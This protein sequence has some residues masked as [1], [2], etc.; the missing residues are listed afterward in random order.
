[1]GALSRI[2]AAAVACAA[3]A[4]AAVLVIGDSTPTH[5]VQPSRTLT[6]RTSFAPPAAQFGD[7]VVARVVVLADRS[8]LD[9]QHLRITAGVAPLSQLATPHVTRADRGR[10]AVVTYEVPAVCIDERCLGGKSP[11]RLRLP[12]VHVEAPRL[13]G[14]VLRATAGWPALELR[15]RVTA[16]DLASGRPAFRADR[17]LP[18]VSYRISP[19]TLATLLDVIAALLAVAGVAWAARQIAVLVRRRRALDTR[20]ELERAVALV[21]EAEMRPSGDRRRAVGLLARI[22][23]TRDAP[24]AREAGDLAWSR[25]KPAAADLAAL[26]DR[27]GGEER[28]P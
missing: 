26:A 14:G 3:A 22:L 23:R 17:S 10:L 27:A 6:L 2:A 28:S 20:S 18:A 24:L 16:A 4:V 9:A 5:A 7:R 13:D 8:V 19:H 15:G 11:R 25:P 21:R 1:M 12:A